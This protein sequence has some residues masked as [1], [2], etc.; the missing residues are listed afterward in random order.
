MNKPRAIAIAIGGDTSSMM[1]ET[2]LDNC[3]GICE[4]KKINVTISISE[5]E[6]D[7]STH[8]VITGPAAN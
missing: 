2:I 8:V 6:K 5:T 3:L 1:I 4:K 7:Q